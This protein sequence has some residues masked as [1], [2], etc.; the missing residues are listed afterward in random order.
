MSEQSRNRCIPNTSLEY[1]FENFLMKNTDKN[2][3]IHILID[4]KSVFVFRL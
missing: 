3:R 2:I 1:Y 4:L